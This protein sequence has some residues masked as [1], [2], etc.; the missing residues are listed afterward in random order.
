MPSNGKKMIDSLKRKINAHVKAQINLSWIG[1]AD[2]RDHAIINERAE[3]AKN[4]LNSC[5][6]QLKIKLE[7]PHGTE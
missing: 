7:M 4:A 2:P 5:I 1:E 3:N 6:R